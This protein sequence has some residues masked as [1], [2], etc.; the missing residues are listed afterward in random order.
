VEGRDNLDDLNIGGDI[1]LKLIL[2]KYCIKCGLDL[3]GSCCGLL[4]DYTL[5]RI[6]PV[7]S[8]RAG[9]CFYYVNNGLG[10]L[11]LVF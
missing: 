2:K 9:K 4:A 8:R 11:E 5:H 10:P 6:F 3:S 7:V 1:I